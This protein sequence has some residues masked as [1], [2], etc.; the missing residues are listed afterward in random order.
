[1]EA[2]QKTPE[3]EAFY[4]KIDGENLVAHCM[5]SGANKTFKLQSVTYPAPA[6]ALAFNPQRSTHA[7]R[8]I[9]TVR[10]TIEPAATAI[11]S[12][13]PATAATSA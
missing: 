5:L 2:V 7:T 1:M 12:V 9:S 3:R 11:R 13:R 10:E 6:G 4:K 8:E